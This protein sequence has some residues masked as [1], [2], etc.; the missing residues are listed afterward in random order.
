[1]VSNAAERASEPERYAYL[2]LLQRRSKVV[3]SNGKIRIDEKDE[4]KWW[5]GRS[6]NQADS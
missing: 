5:P 4:M 1:M 3:F 6:P 2:D